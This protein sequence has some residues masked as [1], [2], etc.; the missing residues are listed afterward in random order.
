MTETPAGPETPQSSEPTPRPTPRPTPK[1]TPR[2]TPRALAKPSESDAAAGKEAAPAPITVPVPDESAALA[3]AAKFGRVGDDGSVYVTDSSGERLVGQVPGV[4]ADEAISLYLRRFLDLQAKVL[5]FEARLGSAELNIKE[6]DQTLAKLKEE[7]AEPSAVGDLDGLRAK[8]TALEDVAKQR[9]A[10]LEAERAAARETAIADRT[11]IVEAAEA[12]AA[13]DPTKIQWRPAGDQ[14]RTLLDQWKT[15]QRSGPRID[16]PTEEALWK[17]FSHARTAFDRE[18]RHYFAQLEQSN[19]QAKDAKEALVAEAEQ[20]S[21]STQWGPTAAAYRELMNRWKAAGRANRKDDD[22]LWARFRAAQDT[23]FAAREA[24]NAATDAE[25]GKNLQ[26]KEGILAEAEKLVPVTDLNRAKATLRD[27][28]DQ[29]EAAGRVPRND[30]QRIEGRMRA[31]ETAIRETE[32]A[33]WKRKNPETQA[34]A[35]GAAAQLEASIAQD[36]AAL[37]EATAKGDKRKI[38]DLEAALTA[39]RSWLEQVNKAA[40]DARG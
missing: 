37:E 3:A 7:T 24:D 23:F 36:E 8:I 12:I 10:E 34:R 27:L 40:Q 21:S 13:T 14:L 35:E 18:R 29:W 15:S 26:V 2:P 22:A 30:V 17:R 31:V 11:K 4:A 9:R 38:K 39:K 20:L 28:Q 5:L 1:P 25:Y 6:I 16:R 19:A 32:D 33:E